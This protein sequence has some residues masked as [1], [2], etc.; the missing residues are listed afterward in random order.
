MKPLFLSA[1]AIIITA[2]L[3]LDPRS[4]LYGIILC[5]GVAMIVLSQKLERKTH[6]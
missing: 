3:A 2:R 1:L 5:I 4:D 6:D